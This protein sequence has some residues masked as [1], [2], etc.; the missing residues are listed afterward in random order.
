MAFRVFSKSLAD[1]DGLLWFHYE[2]EGRKAIVLQAHVVRKNLRYISASGV[3]TEFHGEC[4]ERYHYS[5]EYGY[6]C[7][8]IILQF[9]SPQGNSHTVVFTQVGPKCWK[10][11][12]PVTREFIHITLF[13]P[14]VHEYVHVPVEDY[15]IPLEN[16]RDD[17]PSDDWVTLSN[18]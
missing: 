12:H 16:K 11:R 3:R 2:H 8:Q 15:A 9:H 10:G 1:C 4:S 14:I 5:R 18:V 13:Q 6:D 7:H 17:H